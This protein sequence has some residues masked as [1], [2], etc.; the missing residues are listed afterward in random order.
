M[1]T[2]GSDLEEHAP[3]ISRKSTIKNYLYCLHWHYIKTEKRGQKQLQVIDLYD[4][5]LNRPPQNGHLVSNSGVPRLPRLPRQTNP[6]SAA[7]RIRRN[8]AQPNRP[9]ML[10]SIRAPEIFAKPASS[11]PT[12][13][14][15]LDAS[16]RLIHML[17]GLSSRKRSI[18]TVRCNPGRVEFDRE[19]I[20]VVSSVQVI[21]Q[22]K[23]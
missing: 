6:V 20:F 16:S 21:Y 22:S 18:E 9:N 5:H 10:R 17:D 13:F 8:A 1:A 7:L 11:I 15:P 4:P 23:P 3:S 2:G 14:R 12:A 19:E